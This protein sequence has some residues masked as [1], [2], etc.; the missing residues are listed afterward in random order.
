MRTRLSYLKDLLNKSREQLMR[1]RT[2]I[3]L[4]E[5]RIEVIEMEIYHEK[6]AHESQ[7]K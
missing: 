6:N 2:R 4:I 1:A 7:K 3:H 5:H